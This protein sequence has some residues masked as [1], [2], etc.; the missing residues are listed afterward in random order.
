MS[1]NKQTLEHKIQNLI[2]HIQGK[3][4]TIKTIQAAVNN[5]CNFFDNEKIRKLPL[6]NKKIEDNLLSS[7]H[8][9]ELLMLMKFQRTDTHL[10]LKKEAVTLK[11]MIYFKQ[12]IEKALVRLFF[13]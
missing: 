3:E 13:E 12:C 10:E 9:I 2:N 8:A 11:E 7:P 5:I 4:D 1:Q 6:K